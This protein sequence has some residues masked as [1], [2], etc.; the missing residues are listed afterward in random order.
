LF[1]NNQSITLAE[2]FERL[3]EIPILVEKVTGRGV[4]YG[5]DFSGWVGVFHYS[6]QD[7]RIHIKEIAVL[8]KP[9]L[10]KPKPDVAQG[11]YKITRE[12]LS[13]GKVDF[14]CVDENL[15]IEWEGKIWMPMSANEPLQVLMIQ[16]TS[17]RKWQNFG[18]RGKKFLEDNGLTIS[19]LEKA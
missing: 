6:Q 16:K 1:L 9:I 7:G 4:S 17:A 3:L 12:A 2:K 5:I 19:D 8:D 10:G 11:I 14:D 18:D 13:D 15:G